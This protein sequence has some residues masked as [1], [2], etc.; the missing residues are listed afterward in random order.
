LS[1][2][3]LPIYFP[4]PMSLCSDLLQD[5]ADT[6]TPE[7]LTQMDLTITTLRETLRALKSNLKILST[8]FSTLKS[9]PTTAELAGM[10]EK[11]REENK[12]KSE[13][14]RGFKEGSVRILTREEVETA[15]KE[16]RYWG[17]KRRARKSAF[18]GLEGMLME[19]MTREEIWERAGLEEDCY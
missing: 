4:L 19:G 10:I 14:L 7:Q 5:P 12:V 17:V 13:K 9:A 1:P 8:K 11:L 16:L 15:E 3:I 6:A 2:Q 18:D